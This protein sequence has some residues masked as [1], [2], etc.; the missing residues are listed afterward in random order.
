MH[1]TMWVYWRQT[2]LVS[3]ENLTVLVISNDFAWTDLH[4]K[5]AF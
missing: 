4:K 1:N 2:N 3:G 5:F